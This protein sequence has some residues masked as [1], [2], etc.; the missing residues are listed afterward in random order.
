MYYCFYLI[1]EIQICETQPCGAGVCT[2]TSDGGFTCDCEG[3]LYTGERCENAYA[4]I[5]PIG[6]LTTDEPFVI[7][8]TIQYPDKTEISIKTSDKTNLEIVD[9]NKYNLPA[10]LLLRRVVN[11]T[12]VARSAGSYKI[13]YK[14]K[15]FNKFVQP[16]ES[17]VL[18]ISKEASG[19]NRNNYFEAL[20]L[21]NGILEPGCCTQRVSVAKTLCPSSRSLAFQ[22]PCKW[23]GSS[24]RG[25]TSN[26]V[27]MATVNQINLPLSITG[28]K[29]KYNS[30]SKQAKLEI[31]PLLNTATGSNTCSKCSK[32]SAAIVPFDANDLQ[33]FLNYDSLLKTF[34]KRI[35]PQLPSWLSVD[36]ASGNSKSKIAAYDFSSTLSTAEDL[37]TLEGCE[38]YTLDENN[39]AKVYFVLRAFTDIQV[40]IDSSQ[41]L[42]TSSFTK[43]QCFVLDICSVT[44]L[45]LHYLVPPSLQP[46]KILQT[47]FFMNMIANNG[48]TSLSNM[49]LFIDKKVEHYNN[50]DLQYWDGV[51]Y[52]QPVLAKSE[53]KIET[54]I[55]KNFI[56]S[57]LEVRIIYVGSVFYNSNPDNGQVSRLYFLLACMQI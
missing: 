52:F 1:P 47:T 19:N 10:S 56:G 44:G 48:S 45:Q 38:S 22:S 9:D 5:S 50:V 25:T 46:S 2:V 29:L 20:G 14:I 33:T 36:V 42:I 26:G 16:E 17:T 34:F 31:S 21:D 28:I 55:N 35:Q 13:S 40:S 32:C 30:R 54:E 27:I 49:V 53:V 8:I 41:S 37:Q 4:I 23:S 18:A 11:F 15:P 57:N 6:T 12:L 51:T 7:S 43:P 39:K 3:T 24:K